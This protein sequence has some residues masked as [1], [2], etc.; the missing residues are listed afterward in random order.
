MIPIFL[1]VLLPFTGIGVSDTLET[2]YSK[3]GMPASIHDLNT[4]S[5]QA[6][7]WLGA[8]YPMIETT[9]PVVSSVLPSQG[10]NTYGPANVQDFNIRTAW[11]PSSRNKGIGEWIEFVF[12]Y[13][14]YA[15]GYGEVYQFYGLIFIF[16][17]YCK[18]E[19][20]WRDNS[21]VKKLKVY[22]NGHPL[23]YVQLQDNWYFQ[24]FNIGK[25]FKYRVARKYMDAPYEIVNGDRLRFEIVEVYKGDKYDDVGISEFDCAGGPN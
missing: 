23:C 1:L 24:S 6:G 13:P 21:R 14:E 12:N 20:V 15:P 8:A 16:N 22:Y 5:T 4:D 25:F 10:K 9:L 18:S 17:G 7:Y 19:Q 3:S 2:I 11:I